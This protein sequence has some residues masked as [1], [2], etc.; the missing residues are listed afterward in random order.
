ME[1]RPLA[2]ASGVVKSALGL[3]PCL[4]A[5]GDDRPD[6]RADTVTARTFGAMDA[7]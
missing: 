3:S 6:L 7:I 2:F 4:S 1:G 5:I